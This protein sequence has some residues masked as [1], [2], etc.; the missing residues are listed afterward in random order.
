MEKMRYK[1]RL[2]AKQR[3][4]RRG[5]TEDALEDSDDDIGVGRRYERYTQEAQGDEYDDNEDDLGGFG[6]LILTPSG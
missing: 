1:R 2:E 3:T 5:L 6:I 4:S